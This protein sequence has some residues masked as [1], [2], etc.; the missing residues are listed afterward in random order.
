MRFFLSLLA[1]S[2]KNNNVQI[3][4]NNAHTTERKMLSH[5]AVL[6][7]QGW[8]YGLF[9][10]P[11]L[12]V[13]FAAYLHRRSQLESH[14]AHSSDSMSKRNFRAAEFLLH[15]LPSAAGLYISNS[16]RTIDIQSDA[17]EQRIEK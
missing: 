10:P 11:F 5:F 17:G 6:F 13:L 12:A 2:T 7:S 15:V 4:P 1:S 8:F 9:L 16:V 14:Y 3:Y